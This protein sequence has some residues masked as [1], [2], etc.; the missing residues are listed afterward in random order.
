V[1]LVIVPAEMNV[2]LASAVPDIVAPSDIFQVISLP[3]TVVV[4]VAGETPGAEGIC[5]LPS[6][7]TTS[8]RS[9]GV[10]PDHWKAECHVPVTLHPL[11]LPDDEKPD[12]APDELDELGDPTPDDEHAARNTAATAA[13]KRT[14]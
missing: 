10:R 9:P 14:P 13:P 3:L 4:P 7:A 8:D 12:D 1:L 2:Q 11:P 6:S 5:T